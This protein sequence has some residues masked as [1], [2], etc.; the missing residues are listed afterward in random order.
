MV[1]LECGAEER[2]EDLTQLLEHM[3]KIDI[4][5]SWSHFEP[6]EPFDKE[7]AIMKRDE[8]FK[9]I[10]FEIQQIKDNLQNNSYGEHTTS[11]M[12]DLS[13]FMEVVETIDSIPITRITGSNMP[14]YKIRIGDFIIIAN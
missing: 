3:N 14:I 10:N 6:T 9:Y 8:G 12:D 2:I 4:E 13:Y 1:I 5:T 7:K 11:D